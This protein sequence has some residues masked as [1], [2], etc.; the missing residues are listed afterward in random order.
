MLQ[1]LG[2][3]AFNY[4]LESN[5]TDFKK[6]NFVHNSLFVSNFE[7]ALSLKAKGAGKH[8]L[9]KNVALS[10]QWNNSWIL[11]ANQIRL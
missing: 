9:I 4:S 2:F 10:L 3:N 7:L 5:K 6:R 11:L 1:K 8:G